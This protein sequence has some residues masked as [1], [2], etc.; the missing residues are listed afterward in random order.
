M[1]I[2]DINDYAVSD[3]VLD[4]KEFMER[5]LATLVGIYDQAGVPLPSRR[6]WTLQQPA[7]DCEQAAVSLIQIY[8]GV[9]GDQA[10]RPQQCSVSPYS[11]VLEISITR[12]YP[13]GINGKAVPPEKIMQASAM[14]AAD[15]WIL[16]QG[17]SAFDTTEDGIPGL[18]VITTISPR[19]PLGGVQTT[20][21]QLTLAVM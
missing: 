9:P 20:V 3:G 1:A 19:E 8:L 4:L 21:M 17:A 14:A 6:F 7:E 5:A 2:L 18:G 12:D 10:S 11:A 15:A 16:A 13:L